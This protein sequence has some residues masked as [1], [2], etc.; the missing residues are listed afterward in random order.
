MYLMLLFLCDT[1][2]LCLHTCKSRHDVII[3]KFVP[4]L[5]EILIV[6]VGQGIVLSDEQRDLVATAISAKISGD[7]ADLVCERFVTQLGPKLGA[8][9]TKAS[10]DVVRSVGR[11]IEDV[12][13]GLSHDIQQLRGDM[14]KEM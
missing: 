11:E 2:A 4:R 13:R 5:R 3:A 1:T 7:V 8:S 10:E 14:V 9:I 12:R 6:D